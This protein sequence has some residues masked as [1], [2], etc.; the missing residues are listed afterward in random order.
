[1]FRPK[2]HQLSDKSLCLVLTEVN[3]NFSTAS[4]KR[5]RRLVDDHLLSILAEQLF[6]GV[7]F[8]CLLFCFVWFFNITKS[9]SPI[10]GPAFRARG[11]RKMGALVCF[12][13]EG[14]KIIGLPSS[15]F[16]RGTAATWTLSLNQNCTFL[17]GHPFWSVCKILKYDDFAG[18]RLNYSCESQVITVRD[19][20]HTKFRAQPWVEILH[21]L[22]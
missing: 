11:C 13:P 16:K 19:T 5:L 17:E 4:R 3:G 9:P 18:S 15:I 21:A 2:P 12:G 22:T 8:F 1:M 20:A 10:W 7:F 14:R 6:F